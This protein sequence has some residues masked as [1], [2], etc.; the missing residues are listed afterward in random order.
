MSKSFTSLLYKAARL[1]ADLRAVRK[2]PA[3]VGK[4]MVR[5][6]VYRRTN[7]LLGSLLRAVLK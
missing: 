4:R 1:S 5:K 6:A 2:G 3:A 7:G